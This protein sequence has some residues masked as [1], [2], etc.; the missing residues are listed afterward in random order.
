MGIVKIIIL[1]LLIWLGFRLY[2][3]IQHRKSLASEPK[4]KQ[5]YGDL[6]QCA[7]CGIHLPK[8]EAQIENGSYYCTSQNTDCSR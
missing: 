6:V 1:G 8:N 4:P 2:H 7:A 5:I 3:A